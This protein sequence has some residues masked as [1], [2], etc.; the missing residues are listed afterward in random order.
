MKKTAIKRIKTAFAA[1][2]TAAALSFAAI[3]TVNDVFALKKDPVTA[4]I[5]FESE[6]AFSVGKK[7]KKNGIIALP[8]VY[9][10]YCAVKG[11]RRLTV[12]GVYTLSGD[13]SYDEL[14]RTVCTEKR[15]E[16]EVSVT[17]PEGSTSTDI[18]RLLAAAG[19]GREDKLLEAMNS[20]DY[21]F[22]FVRALASV[23]A[24][25]LKD[26]KVMLEG[27]LFPDTYYF[28]VDGTERQ[29]VEK[30]LKN[31]DARF[32][33]R[34]RASCASQGF[35]VDEAIT[36][37]SLV[38]KEAKHREDFKKVASV[39]RNRLRSKRLTKLESDASVVYALGRRITADDLYTDS[40]YNTYKYKGL[41]PGA[42]CNPGKRAIL[43]A[44]EPAD[45]DYLYF[46]SDGAGNMF[47]SVTKEEHDANIERISRQ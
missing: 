18:I 20:L 31:F 47:Y 14:R 11:D 43:A 30:M 34:Y 21:D 40:P 2:L 10:V 45:T 19:I 16:S 25:K 3:F 6:D 8:H 32:N 4:E 13:M 46:V 28:S 33:E 26:R 42:I 36:L 1:F 44:L 41:P 12:P 29:A 38:E 22:D 5:S 17:I 27:Y 35:T 37:A 7:L 39:F 9:G 23:P 24:E 15:G